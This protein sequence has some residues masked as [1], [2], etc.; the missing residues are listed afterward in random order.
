MFANPDWTIAFDTDPTAA[1]DARKKWFK[2]LSSEKAL[3]Y[4]YH[5]P[6]P[7][8][9]HIASHSAGY[10]WLNNPWQFEVSGA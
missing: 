10:L 4:G 2:R 6:F 3:C 5:V 8:F 1:R 9:G 7:G